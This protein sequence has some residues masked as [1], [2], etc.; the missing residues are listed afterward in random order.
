MLDVV[1]ELKTKVGR[2]FLV[3]NRVNGA[4]PEPLAAAAAELKAGIGTSFYEVTPRGPEQVS[5]LFDILADL[6][7]T[8]AASDDPDESHAG[9]VSV[10]VPAPDGTEALIE[11]VRRTTDSGISLSDVALRTP[12]LDEVFLTL[13]GAPAEADQPSDEAEEAHR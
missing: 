9:D 2:R 11:I 12:T 1:D 3:I 10:T 8:R 5:Q 6:G 13:T 7:A 4:L